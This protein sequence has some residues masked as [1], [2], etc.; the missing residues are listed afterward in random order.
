MPGYE[1]TV[2]MTEN[3]LRSQSRVVSSRSRSH[4][5]IR[6]ISDLVRCH[7]MQWL[8]YL[9]EWVPECFESLVIP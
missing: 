1:V 5:R 3:S 7:S 2:N 8:R 9:V 4:P 6:P